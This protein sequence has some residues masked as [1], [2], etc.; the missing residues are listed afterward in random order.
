[1]STLIFAQVIFR[2]FLN[3]PLSWSEEFAIYL[4]AWCTFTG[5]AMVLRNDLHVKVTEFI[6]LIKNEKLRNTVVIFSQL[7]ILTFSLT[8]LYISTGTV[9]HMISIDQRS[10]SMP[11]LNIG[12]VFIDVPLSAAIMILFM[13]ERIIATIKDKKIETTEEE[14]I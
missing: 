7:L 3:R 6:N 4:F 10:P 8:I 13:T 1:M 5:A 14:I 2:Y 9:A 11:W 12:Y